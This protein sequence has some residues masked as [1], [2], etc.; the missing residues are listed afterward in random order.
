HLINIDIEFAGTT[1]AAFGMRF[2]DRSPGGGAAFDYDDI[3]DFDVFDDLKRNGVVYFRGLGS[4]RFL[5]SQFEG[6]VGNQCKGWGDGRRGPFLGR[7]YVCEGKDV[8]D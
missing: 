8:G 5:Q 4:N 3:A 1:E 2:G 6:G 7:V